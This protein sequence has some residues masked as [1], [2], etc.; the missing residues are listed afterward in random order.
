MG[1]SV[2]VKVPATSG[3]MGSGFDCLSLALDFWNT[4]HVE[5]GIDGFEIRGEGI[6]SLPRGTFN[7]IYSCLRIPFQASN[8]EFPSVRI[9]CDNGIPLA[10]GLGSSSAAAVAGLVAGN[11]LSGKPFTRQQLLEVAAELEGHPDNVAS[12]LLGGCQIVVRDGSRLVTSSIPIPSELAVVVY[13]PEFAMPT[14][15]ARELLPD[16]VSRQDA[17]YNIGRV[18]LMVNALSTGNLTHL[19]IGA[20]D[21]LHQIAR[22]ALFPQMKTVFRAALEGGAL[23][24]FLSGAGSSVLALTNDREVTI[25]RKMEEA[26]S[27]SGVQ[28]KIKITQPTSEGAQVLD[29]D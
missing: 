22:E 24:V 11:E 5:V 6:D 27:K 9:I 25:G 13:I 29:V 28:G 4:L 8:Q 20:E 7:L 15:Q 10:R 19:A 3:N 26:A 1:E 14:A 21:R 18:A 12:A 23:A 17:V 16:E 2:T